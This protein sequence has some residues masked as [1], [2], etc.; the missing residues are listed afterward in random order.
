MKKTYMFGLILAFCLGVI[1]K[2]ALDEIGYDAVT[3]AHAEVAGMDSFE[4]RQDFDFR[5]AV[6]S[7]ARRQ[8]ESIILTELYWQDYNNANFEEAVQSVIEGCRVSSDSGRI[9][10]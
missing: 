1:G 4:L 8:A 10:C 7:I 6:K 3:V 2:T 9:S 5:R